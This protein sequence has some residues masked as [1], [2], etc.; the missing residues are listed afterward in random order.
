MSGYTVGPTL[1]PEAAPWPTWWEQTADDSC[2]HEWERCHLLAD[3]KRRAFAEDVIRCR[4]CLVPRCGHSEDSDPCMERRHHTGLHIRL[5]GTWEPLG[6]LP[7]EFVDYG[8]G[9][10]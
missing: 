4:L 7:D 8:R 10:K 3:G 6:G 1:P 5:S 9:Q 2:A